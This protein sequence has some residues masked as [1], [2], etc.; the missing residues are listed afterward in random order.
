MA[1]IYVAGCEKNKFVKTEFVEGIVTLDG[2]PVAEA[3]VLFNP[4]TTGKGDPALGHTDADGH[5][6]A[7]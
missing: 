7:Y 6:S 4:V 2:Q 3:A 5:Y 1:L